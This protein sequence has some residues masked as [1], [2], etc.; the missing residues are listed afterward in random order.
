MKLV[1]E[2]LDSLNKNNIIDEGKVED[3]IK[4]LHDLKFLLRDKSDVKTLEGIFINLD[5]QGSKQI[6]IMRTN[7]QKLLNLWLGYLR[8]R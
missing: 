8:K 3:L 2:V 7:L 6:G 1:D 4:G 5:K